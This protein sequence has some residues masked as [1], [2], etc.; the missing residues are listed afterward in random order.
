MVFF[1]IAKDVKCV[2]T[3]FDGKTEVLALSERFFSFVA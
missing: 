3:V 1:L 2:N